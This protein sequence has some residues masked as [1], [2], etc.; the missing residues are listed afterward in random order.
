MAL[1]SFIAE[2]KACPQPVWSVAELCRVLEVSR[3]GFHGWERR[4]RSE[5]DLSDATLAVEIES[6]YVASNE[7]YGAPRVHRWLA[8]QGFGVGHNRV[9]RIM[10][11]QGWSGR[12]GRRKVRTTVPDKTA[13]PAPDLVKRQFSPAEPDQTWCGDITYIP[14]GE[15][16][17][18]LSTVID[19]FSRRVIGWSLADHMRAELV[20]D[21]LGMAVAT[22]GGQ[23]AGAVFHSDRGSQ[24]TSGE[25]GQL[26]RQLEVRQSMGATGVCWDNAAAEAFFASLKKELVHRYRWLEQADARQAIVRWIEGWYNPRRLHSSI[27]YRTPIEAEADWHA[28]DRKTRRDGRLAA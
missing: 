25:F 5:R 14:T 23:A 8:R 3:S 9:A 19:L 7:T 13:A 4:G 15:G 1:Y 17:L 11:E 6:I 18:Y 12:L 22:R 16:W 28:Q 21:A 20:G 24:Y 2:E 27:G 10:R 26:C